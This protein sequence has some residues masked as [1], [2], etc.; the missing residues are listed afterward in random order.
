MSFF[1]YQIHN[2]CQKN[3]NYYHRI[4]NAILIKYSVCAEI[5][6]LSQFSPKNKQFLAETT[7]ITQL[8]SINTQFLPKTT[9]LVQKM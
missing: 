2:L 6:F 1:Y 4:D 9:L 5:T 7:Q 8:L 3:P